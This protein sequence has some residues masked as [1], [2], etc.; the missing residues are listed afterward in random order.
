MTG[1]LSL[2]SNLGDRRKN[3]EQALSLLEN[4]VFKVLK[5][6]SFY[7][8]EPWGGVEQ[9]PFYN[10]AAKIESL[11]EPVQLL[12]HCQ[13]VEQFMGRERQLHWGPRVIDIDILTYHTYIISTP[14]LTLPHPYLEK[15]EF[16]LAPLREIEPNLIL[17]S[18][19]SIKTVKG[20]GKVQKISFT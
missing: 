4:P 17:P 5:I 15:R 12:H 10:L 7:E 9:A 3:L 13:K 1:Y 14:E 16:V 8:T 18:G 2:G 11:L 19:K 20:E 6:S